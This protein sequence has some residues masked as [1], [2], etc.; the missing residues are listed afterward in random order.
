MSKLARIEP[1]R[2]TKIIRNSARCKNCG[3]SIES[4]HV[5]DFVGCRCGKIAV[6]GGYEYLRRVGDLEAF[7]ET[8][9]CE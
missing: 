4:K 7:E 3:D 5:H 2:I 9:I 1:K 6:D 8:S